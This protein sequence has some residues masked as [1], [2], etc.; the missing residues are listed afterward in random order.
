LEK[1]DIEEDG[2]FGGY[3]GAVMDVAED[4]DLTAELS[5][6]SS[7]WGLGAGIAQKF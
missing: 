3:I 5:F 4:C 6:T 1:A 2:N 7:G